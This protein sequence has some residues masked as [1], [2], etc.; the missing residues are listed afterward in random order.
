[1]PIQQKRIDIAHQGIMA[2]EKSE[3]GFVEP[4]HSDESCIYCRVLRVS[5]D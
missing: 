4:F 3:L 2:L 1:M 5:H